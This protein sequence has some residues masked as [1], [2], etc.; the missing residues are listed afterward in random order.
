MLLLILVIILKTNYVEDMMVKELL[1]FQT[2][3]YQVEQSSK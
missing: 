2:Q 3:S 1:K